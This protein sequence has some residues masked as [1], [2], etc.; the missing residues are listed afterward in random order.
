M[1]AVIRIRR[2]HF[3]IASLYPVSMRSLDEVDESAPIA[4]R[5]DRK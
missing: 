5:W 3:E 4:I 1:A 2:R